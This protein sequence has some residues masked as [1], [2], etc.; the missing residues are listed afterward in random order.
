MIIPEI[1]LAC[2]CAIGNDCRYDDDCW[3]FSPSITCFEPKFDP[4]YSNPR[5]FLNQ[6][7]IVETTMENL[8]KVIIKKNPIVL[9]GAIFYFTSSLGVL[10]FK[11]LVILSTPISLTSSSIISSFIRYLTLPK[12]MLNSFVT[13]EKIRNLL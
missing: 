2:K 11:G 13:Y 6:W 1:C 4:S 12:I 3:S 7:L 8:E 5:D 9:V 10:S